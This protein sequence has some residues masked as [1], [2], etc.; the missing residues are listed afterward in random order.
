MNARAVIVTGIA[1]G[2]GD[3]IGRYLRDEGW[4]VVGVDRREPAE[5]ACDRLVSFDLLHCKNADR[6]RDIC[7]NPIIAEL[8]GRRL[9]GL[10]NNAA[11]QI[12]SPTRR[13]RFADWEDSLTVNLT[14]PLL[15]VQ[16]FLPLL[17]AGVG[18]VVNIGSVHAQATKREFVTYAAS[19]AALHG[20]TRALAVDLGPDVRVVCLAPAAISTPML[21]DGFARKKEAFGALQDCHPAGRIG[22]PRE[23]ARAT[24]FLLSQE[25]GFLTG[26]TLYL[27]GGVLCRLH[28]PV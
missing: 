19:K 28:D 13:V 16:A 9:G 12:L 15:L 4:F 5:G 21:L 8:G 24:S 1:G 10:V 22:E 23:V 25:S 2:I 26:T 27:D 6:F 7:V 14:A 3:A 11:L 17:E 18:C 20:L